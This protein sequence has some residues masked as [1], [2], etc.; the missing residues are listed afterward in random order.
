[1]KLYEALVMCPAV[2]NQFEPISIS[3]L[4]EVVHHMRPTNCPLDCI[5]SRLLKDVFDT[6][7]PCML[8]LINSCLI[9]G[10]VPAAFKHAVVQPLLKKEHLDPS[11]LSNFRPISKLP[12]LS[13]VLEKVVLTQLQVFLDTHNIQEKFQ[14]GFKPRHSTETALLRVF[15]DLI[16]TVDSGNSAILVLDLT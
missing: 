15:N 10:C 5:P 7:G 11:L 2:L 1:M 9:S 4:S 12:F 13:K 16:L 8:S 3:F 6:V 14:S